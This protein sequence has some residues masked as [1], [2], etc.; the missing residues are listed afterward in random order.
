MRWLMLT[1]CAGLLSACGGTAGYETAAQWDSINYAT[2]AV[3]GGGGDNY[4]S[5]SS[6]MH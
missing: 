2:A 3:P 4:L 5:L 1:L 6:N